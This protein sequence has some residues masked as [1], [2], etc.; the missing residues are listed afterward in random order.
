V[1][2]RQSAGAERRPYAFRDKQIPTGPD[3]I[4]VDDHDSALRTIAFIRMGRFCVGA[5]RTIRVHPHTLGHF[6]LVSIHESMA[7]STVFARER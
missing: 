4:V 2:E 3:R 6:L 7:L 1:L 5:S